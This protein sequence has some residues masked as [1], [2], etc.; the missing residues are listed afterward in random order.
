MFHKNMTN[1]FFILINSELQE[2]HCTRY[3][4]NYYDIYYMRLLI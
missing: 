3:L 4:G 2:G 1:V